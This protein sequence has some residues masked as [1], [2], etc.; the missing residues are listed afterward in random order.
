MAK[1]AARLF[2][3]AV[4]AFLLAGC[5]GEPLPAVTAIPSTETAAATSTLAPA[6]TATR[7]PRPTPTVWVSNT[8]RL[9][10]PFLFG[11]AGPGPTRTRSPFS[12]TA[13]AQA[14]RPTATRTPRPTPSVTPVPQ[15]VLERAL[16]QPAD[17]PRNWRPGDGG[18]LAA[19]E[20]ADETTTV[21]L[22]HELTRRHTQ[23]AEVMYSG[24]DLGPQLFHQIA[25]YP[26]G[27]AEAMFASFAA[28]A[29]AC[30]DVRVNMG[31]G[32]DLRLQRSYP[33]FPSIGDETL[34]IHLAN[35]PIF[36]IG[37]PEIDVV[38]IR[39]GNVIL[40]IGYFN[41]GRGV[42]SELTRDWAERAASKWQAA[43]R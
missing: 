38:K 21:F 14:L 25:V 32:P 12:L 34:A 23:S 33:D 24:G 37:R 35:P 15:I 40:T 28:A 39:I 1:G 27:E 43:V 16:L 22:C 11:T 2:L 10:S 18:A 29:E 8:P 13:T 26:P 4:S 6:A 7:T 19:I 41:T 5:D 31:T 20:N 3:I 30:P 42:D 17:V 36:L 9:T